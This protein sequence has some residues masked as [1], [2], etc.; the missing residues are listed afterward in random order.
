MALDRPFDPETRIV[1]RDRTS[2]IKEREFDICVVGSGASGMSAA[3]EAARAGQKVAL[4]DG[5][6]SL[7]GQAVNSI[8]GMFCGLYSP[9][10]NGRQLT[11]G[12]A[13]E[14]LSDLGAAGDLH[15]VTGGIMKI[16]MYN[17]VALG[18]WVERK[19]LEAGITPLTGAIIRDVTSDGRR[20]KS[21]DISTRYGDIRLSA[22]GFIDATGD[23]ALTWQAGFDCRVHKNGQVYGSQ[24]LIIED[25]VDDKRP[26]WDEM[27]ARIYEKGQD[28]GMM[29][30]DGFAASFPG[31]NVAMVNMT[32]IETPLDPFD[33]AIKQIEGKEQADRTLVFLKNEFPEA[34]GNARVRTYGL[35]GIRQTRW[36]VGTHHLTV[37]EVRAATKFDDAIARC[38]WPLEQHHNREGYVWETFDENHIHTIPLGSLTVA[39]ADNLVA[40]GRCIDGDST[41]LSSV[42]VMGPCIAMG[43]AAAHALDI[44]GSGSV[45]QIDIARL[46]ERIRHNLE[47]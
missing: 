18:R 2:G 21:L 38:S 11:R 14:L 3:I 42:R 25:F 20:I 28:Y 1:K 26:S 5:L 4:V 45:H 16:A 29:R 33:A 37:D 36:I 31:R 10:K 47:D 32:H 44:A 23:A 7:G 22:Q 24:M 39:D 40:V 17:E 6:P 27:A 41:A 35:P 30:R 13:D 43:A 19:I 12:I 8:I 9:G 15:V 46:Q 34:F